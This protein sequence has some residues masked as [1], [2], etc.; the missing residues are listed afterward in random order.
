MSAQAITRR[1]WLRLSAGAG[2]ALALDPPSL[3][4]LQSGNYAGKVRFVGFDSSPK[5]VEALAK[6]EIDSLTLQ[7][8]FHM[9]YMG[10]KTAVEHLRGDKV[11]ER[12]DTGVM[13]V[14]KV[15]MDEPEIRELLSPSL[16]K[17]LK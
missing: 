14:T 15:N 6:G 2:A 5:L 10:V 16:D 9:G 3:L 17:W 1:D 7:N 12:V 4:A 11:D 13:L 8:P